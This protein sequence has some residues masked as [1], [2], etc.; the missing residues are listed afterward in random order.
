MYFKHYFSRHVAGVM[1]GCHGA[2]WQGPPL[3]LGTSSTPAIF[4]E[5]RVRP[6]VTKVRVVFVDGTSQTIHPKQGYVLATIRAGHQTIANRPTRFVAIGKTGT[7]LG[8][9]KLP[10]PPKTHG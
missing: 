7:V 10:A 5:G 3:Q 4:I 2:S 8:V 9:Q 6:D 1:E